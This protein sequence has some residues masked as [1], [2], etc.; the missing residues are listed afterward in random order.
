M[1]AATATL[2]RAPESR[3]SSRFKGRRSWQALPT[4]ADAVSPEATRKGLPR[5]RARERGDAPRGDRHLAGLRA[6]VSPLRARRARAR[7]GHLHAPDPDP[8]LRPRLRV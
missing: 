6:R 3:S 8:R 4:D 2:S 7:G 1:R 5:I